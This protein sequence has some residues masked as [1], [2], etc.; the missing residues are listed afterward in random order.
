MNC[1]TNMIH[2]I[3]SPKVC[4]TVIFCSVIT[5][6]LNPC[7]IPCVL[8]NYRKKCICL[9]SLTVSYS[10]VSVKVINVAGARDVFPHTGNFKCEVKLLI[11][12][13][14]DWPFII[15]FTIKRY[16]KLVQLKMSLKL[17]LKLQCKPVC[18]SIKLLLSFACRTNNSIHVWMS[19]SLSSVLLFKQSH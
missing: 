5:C 8:W 15:I 6:A 9:M 19:L 3:T 4:I 11:F 17:P 14:N 16:I 12:P 2:N 13:Q 18:I 7:I 10:A 1:I